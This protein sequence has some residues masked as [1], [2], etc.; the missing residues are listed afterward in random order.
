MGRL[1]IRLAIVA[2][3]EVQ[4]SVVTYYA[5]SDQCTWNT[6]SFDLDIFFHRMWSF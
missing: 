6:Y 1:L 5:N 3:Y 2:K 4:S